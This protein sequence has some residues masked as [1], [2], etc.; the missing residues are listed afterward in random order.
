MSVALLAVGSRLSL[1][2]ILTGALT[3]TG[4]ATGQSLEDRLDED[5]FLQGLTELQLEDLLRHY[6]K[7]HPPDD[8][9]QAA[10]YEIAAERMSLHDPAT[11]PVDRLAAI[12]RILTR[13]AALLTEG[14]NDPRRPSWLADQASDLF[15]ELLAYEASGLTA[16]AGLASPE[17]LAR[18]QRVAQEMNELT[19]EAELAIEQTLM[20][21]EAQDGFARDVAA[22]LNRQRLD[23]DERRRRIPF[24][25]GVAAFLMADLGLI[26]DEQRE[27]WYGLAVDA[28]EPLEDQLDGSLGSRA[29]LYLALALLGLGQE[30]RAK[31]LLDAVI[32]NE[33]TAAPDRFL[34]RLE[35][36]NA[37][38]GA[39]DVAGQLS[40]LTAMKEAYPAA[41]ENAVYHLLLADRHHQILRQ[42][43]Q[44][45]EAFAV[46]TR[47][48]EQDMGIPPMVWRRLVRQ[49]L[50]SA[51]RGDLALDRLPA[52]VLVARA[53]VLLEEPA[54]RHE[55]IRLLETVLRRDDTPVS[56]RATALLAMGRALE[57]DNQQVAAA[58]QYLQLAR[59]YIEHPQAELA[60]ER[61]ASLAAKA[62]RHASSDESEELLRETLEVLTSRFPNVRSIEK[63]RMLSASLAMRQARYDDA[64]ATYSTIGSDST[65]WLEAQLLQVSAAISAADHADGSGQESRWAAALQTIETLTPLMKSVADATDPMRA[66]EARGY[67]EML[68]VFHADVLLKLNRPGQAVTVLEGLEEQ[69]AVPDAVLAEALRLRIRAFR[70]LGRAADAQREAERFVQADPENAGR[71][72]GSM[73]AGVQREVQ[74]LLQI[75]RDQDAVNLA[76]DELLPLARMVQEWLDEHAVDSGQRFQ[77]DRQI[78]DAY[79]FSGAWPEAL[80]IY[81]RLLSRYPDAVQLLLGRAECLYAIGGDELGQA[82]TIYRRLAAA[83]PGTNRASSDCYWQAQ[84]RMLQILDAT[85][86]N[87]AKIVPRIQLLRR[88]DPQLGGEQYRRKLEA[89]Q[90][91]HS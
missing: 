58:K 75:S 68:L 51:A 6:V 30:Q 29:R 26:P 35:R 25:R 31:D 18:A 27:D 91:K 76:R 12:E 40:A 37:A 89:L 48:L 34:A 28:L 72:I 41:M 67:L 17:Q 69:P 55:A 78:A 66:A 56:E 54:R 14:A 4:P 57:S 44:L 77:L 24:L 47:L 20:D 45:Q 21:L 65:R 42:E 8:I 10:R 5:R 3:M 64:I 79:R 53:E 39:Q 83:G 59:D 80:V 36:L 63:W 23:R 1:W 52:I 7:A 70:A 46:Y 9:G 74:S 13:R 85:G 90:S 49:R 50:T 84:V 38:Y 2:V 82:M 22:Q 87:T 15:F 61:S 60:I 43:S 32:E 81:D 11:E 19:S 62:D 71:V 88:Q 16:L 86:R 73:M 33:V